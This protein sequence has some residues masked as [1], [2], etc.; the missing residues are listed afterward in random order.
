M[1][2]QL[3]L[4]SLSSLISHNNTTQGY[5]FHNINEDRTE[6]I[7]CCTC[8]GVGRMDTEDIS[9]YKGKNICSNSTFPMCGAG[10]Y[11]ILFLPFYDSFIDCISASADFHH[12]AFQ[13]N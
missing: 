5:T 2:R 12:P 10:A 1:N 4:V 9:Y 7:T 11:A 8:E 13:M 3:S 6:N